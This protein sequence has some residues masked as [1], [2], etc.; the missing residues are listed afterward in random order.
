MP[1]TN[2]KNSS[3]TDIGD[4]LVGKEYL[5]DRYPEL[6]DTFKQAGVWLARG[7]VKGGRKGSGAKVQT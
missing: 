5:I 2:F 1:T 6:A 4:T 3:G 7:E